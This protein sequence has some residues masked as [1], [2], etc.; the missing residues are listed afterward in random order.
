MFVKLHFQVLKTKDYINVEQAK[1]F[2]NINVKPRI[3][4]MKS[5]F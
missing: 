1:P 4:L 2:D 5:E 3:K